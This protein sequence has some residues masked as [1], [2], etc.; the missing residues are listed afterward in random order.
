MELRLVFPPKLHAIGPSAV[1]C[2]TPRVGIR[3]ET[4]LKIEKD[5]KG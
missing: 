4:L 1:E 2:G 3:A 5:R